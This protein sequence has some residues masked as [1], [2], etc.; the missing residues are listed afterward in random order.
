MQKIYRRC[1]IL[2]IS[3]FG[4]VALG[5][6]SVSQ[7][8]FA[9]DG[10]QL[11]MSINERILGKITLFIAWDVARVIVYGITNSKQTIYILLGVGFGIGIGFGFG[12]GLDR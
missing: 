9:I 11:F 10:P 4:W 6:N 1:K 8:S 12:F 2:G 3:L 5:Y 7:D